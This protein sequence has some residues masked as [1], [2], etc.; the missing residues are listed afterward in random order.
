MYHCTREMDEFWSCVSQQSTA[1]QIT[2]TQATFNHT[3]TMFPKKI[4]PQQ[5]SK[6]NFDPTFFDFLARLHISMWLA[7]LSI[8]MFH[9]NFSSVNIPILRTF[10]LFPTIFFLLKRHK[11]YFKQKKKASPFLQN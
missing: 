4:P 8:C 9:K 10:E 5:K 11:N 1:W 7:Q 2:Q 6:K 3:R